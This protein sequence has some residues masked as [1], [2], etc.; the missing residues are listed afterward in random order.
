MCY[1]VT[2]GVQGRGELKDTVSALVGDVT[3]KVTG[4]R[5]V[6]TRDETPEVDPLTSLDAP[7]RR[8]EIVEVDPLTNLD[9]HTRRAPLELPK[10][11]TLPKIE[12][13][14][15]ITV[16]GPIGVED[17]TSQVP[18]F[19]EVPGL[20]T[21]I[22]GKVNLP[23]A[24]VDVP[25]LPTANLPAVPKVDGLPKVDDVTSKIPSIPKLSSASDVTDNVRL[26]YS[27][28]KV[29]DNGL[30]LVD[31]D[32]NVP[33]LPQVPKLALPDIA[34]LAKDLKLPDVSTLTGIAKLADAKKLQ[35]VESAPIVPF[36]LKPG[37]IS[38]F[39]GSTVEKAQ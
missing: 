35:S 24:P 8:D 33:E 38:G 29:L 2:R 15:V 1:Q 36:G 16:E 34:K 10:T 32:V 27:P 31:V 13:P 4:V 5:T 11:P 26:P 14:G 3:E 7:T 25:A 21:A 23:R 9:V 30:D 28:S 19:E 6:V 20:V 22:A 12:V 17:V 37:E 18:K 39:V